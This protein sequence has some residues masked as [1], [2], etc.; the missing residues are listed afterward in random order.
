MPVNWHDWK[1]TLNLQRI[2]FG[3]LQLICMPNFV[4]CRSKPKLWFIMQVSRGG[5][6]VWYDASLRIL[7]E[8]CKIWIYLKRRNVFLGLC[9]SP[10][11][12]IRDVNLHIALKLHQYGLSTAPGSDARFVTCLRS[13]SIEIQDSWYAGITNQRPLIHDFV[14]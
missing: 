12:S 14:G 7:Q 2:V 8:S 3:I 10:S 9:L 13:H 11:T 6:V 1:S 5:M 4:K